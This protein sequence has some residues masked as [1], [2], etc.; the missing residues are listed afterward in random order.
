MNASFNQCYPRFKSTKQ[1]FNNYVSITIQ[2]VTEVKSFITTYV[3][4]EV[5]NNVN[6]VEYKLTKKKISLD[7]LSEFRIK[8]SNIME[9]TGNSFALGPVETKLL[10]ENLY[11]DSDTDLE[12]DFE[13]T[14]PNDFRIRK[15]F[16][17]IERVN[18][19]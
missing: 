9:V 4:F 17:T 16:N 18:S 19:H 13:T 10:G 7:D 11:L 8:M 14:N 5:F 3:N 12:F 15:V 1:V 2:A 6:E